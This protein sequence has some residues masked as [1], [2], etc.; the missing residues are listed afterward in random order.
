MPAEL[1]DGSQTSFKLK[2]ALSE[3]QN[4]TLD[5]NFGGHLSTFRAES[6]TK[7]WSF[8]TENYTQTTSGQ[9]QNNL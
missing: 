5:W 2:M 9:L 7:S 1:L 6:K 8:K 4:M 3:D